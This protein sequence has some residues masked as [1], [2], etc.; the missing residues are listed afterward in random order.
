[1]IPCLTKPIRT[2]MNHH[3]FTLTEMMIGVS[4]SVLLLTAVYG[5]YN[6]SSQSYNAGISG[7]TLQ[8]GANI[9]L[10]KIIT[11]ETESNVVYR[12]ETSVA[13]MIAPGAL[14]CLLA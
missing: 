2:T 9:V 13:Y 12:L 6:A 3:A 4:F 1:M 7:Q 10:S 11:G 5:F 8:D 14:D